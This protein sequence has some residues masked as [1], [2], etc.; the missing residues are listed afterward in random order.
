MKELPQQRRV[1]LGEDLQV[2]CA[3]RNDPDA[4]TNLMFSWSTPNDINI[5]SFDSGEDSEL[6]A[7]STLSI[8]NVMSSY[9]GRYKCTV[10]NGG[11]VEA[12]FTLIVEGNCENT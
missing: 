3:A 11:S 1:V 8:T 10:N 5:S 2:T 12:N 4:P 7:S 6:T 9:G